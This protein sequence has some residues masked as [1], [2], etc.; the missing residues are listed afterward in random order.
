[1]RSRILTVC[2][3]RGF[4]SWAHDPKWP[5]DAESLGAPQT[6]LNG[7]YGSDNGRRLGKVGYAA[8]SQIDRERSLQHYR[9]Q[10]SLVRPSD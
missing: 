4:R 7:R 1:M 2:S 10:N 6:V 5:Y 8:A 3:I 9:R